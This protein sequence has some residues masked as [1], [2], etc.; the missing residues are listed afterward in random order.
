MD[1]RIIQNDRSLFKRNA[2]IVS[3]VQFANSSGFNCGIN[4][5]GS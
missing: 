5:F 1:H 3:F 4:R 2:L